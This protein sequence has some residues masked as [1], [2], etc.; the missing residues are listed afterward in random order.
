MKKNYFINEYQ[1]SNDIISEVMKIWWY[2]KSKQDY[3]AAIANAVIMF[4][5]FLIILLLFFLEFKKINIIKSEIT[6]ANVLYKNE[7]LNIKVIIDDGIHMITSQN[8]RNISFDD[9]ENI[10]ESVNVIVLLCKGDITV[11]LVKDGFVNGDYENCITYLKKQL[12]KK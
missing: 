9:I 5:L 10:S 4:V 3:I 6:R 1:Y 12:N 7:K 8:E 11:T 2:S